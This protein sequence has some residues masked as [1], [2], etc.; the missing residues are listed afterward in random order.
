MQ[1]PDCRD[2]AT[3]YE[4]VRARAGLSLSPCVTCLPTAGK[5]NPDPAC[6]QLCQNRDDM[7]E[8][9][10]P[11]TEPC[12]GWC[13]SPGSS[14]SGCIPN[15]WV[16]DA[17]PISLTHGLVPVELGRCQLGGCGAHTLPWVQGQLL[18]AV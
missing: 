15:S 6:C 2:V 5:L 9:S 18:C 11:L 7:K 17:S 12:P 1:R 13:Q 4:S 10:L 8:G 3:S 14:G 16:K